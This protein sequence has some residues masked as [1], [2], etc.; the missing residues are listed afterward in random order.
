MHSIIY[1]CY[2][3]YSVFTLLCVYYMAFGFQTKQEMRIYDLNLHDSPMYQVRVLR[4][5]LRID[6]VAWRSSRRG[7]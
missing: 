3:I 5:A 6:L 1:Y 2:T 4:K 7:L